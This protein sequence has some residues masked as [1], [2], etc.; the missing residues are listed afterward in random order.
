MK[1]LI[2]GATGLIGKVLIEKFF[3]AGIKVNFLT[4]KKSKIHSTK[5]A[6]GFYWNPA[7]KKIDLK[8]FDGVDS[9]VHLAG[10]RISKP[11]TKSNK[12]DILSSRIDS[13]RLLFLSLKNNIESFHIKN[14]VSASAIGIYPSEFEKIQTEKT[15]STT[16]SFMERVVVAWEKEIENF[17][18]FN[19]PVAK[20][21]IGLVLSF[22]GGV[23]KALKIPTNLG[24]GTYFGSGEQGQPWIHINDLVEIF[25]KA[26]KDNWDGT[27]NAVAPYP[28]SQEKLTKTLA[29][30]LKRPFFLPPIPKFLL[31]NLIG[32]M[33]HLV[34]DSHWVSSQKILDKGFNFKYENIESAI[35][36][37]VKKIDP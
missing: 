6:S 35:K 26:Y 5:G 29:K 10:S 37:L 2:T 28:V 19:I 21:R 27:F 14:I 36:D 16:N 9:I 8:C 1:V 23:L 31:K 34:L 13:T 7:K 15:N 17:T 11:W 25:F 24:L 33:S 32:E 20:I 22:S 12:K 3:S 18:F 4:T 30:S